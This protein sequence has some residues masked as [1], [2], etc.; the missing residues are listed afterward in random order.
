MQLQEQL[1]ALQNPDGASTTDG[2]DTSGGDNTDTTTSGS[3]AGT[4]TGSTQDY[5]VQ[6]GETP[7]SLA[8]KFYGN[9]A[10]YQR[11]LDANGLSEGDNIQPGD[12]LKIPAAE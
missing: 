3:T 7:W 11:I 1:D 8:Q 10:E 5:T 12:V 4:T 9:G 2:A 6:Q